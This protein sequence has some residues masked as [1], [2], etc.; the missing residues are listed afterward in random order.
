MATQT[1]NT[2]YCYNPGIYESGSGA[3]NATITA[4]TGEVALLKPGAYYLKS[5]ADIGGRL[6][7]GYEPAAP[8]VAL[9]FDERGPGNCS[10]CIFKGNNALT[11]AL[12][13]G[14]KFPASYGG[15]VAATAARDWD[16][17]LVETTGPSSPTPPLPIS[18]L[19]RRDTG[20]PGGTSGCFVPTSP[21]YIEPTACD[22]N[23][24]QTV[25]IFG[26]GDIVLEGVQYAPTDNVT[27]GGNSSSTG[28]VGQII[29]WTLKYSGGISINQQGP[30][31]E[32][33]GIL[34][35]DAACSAPAEPCNP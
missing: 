10:S 30:G 16:N 31:T 18:I 35:I 9:M 19:V 33:N 32:G 1:P 29:S 2:I 26:N 17:Q 15:G 25:N 34:R 3:R 5:G 12:N 8:G 27:I 24:N 28:R 23:K 11:I 13:A 7:G 4:G 21:P 14:T 20:G 6:I 22:A